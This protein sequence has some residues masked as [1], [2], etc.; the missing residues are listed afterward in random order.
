MKDLRKLVIMIA[1]MVAVLLLLAPG[2]AKADTL[3]SVKINKKNIEVDVKTPFTIKVKT[4]DLDENARIS[5]DLQKLN[6]N[7]DYGLENMG[8]IVHARSG[9]V[10]FSNYSGYV[11]NGIV[12]ICRP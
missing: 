5:Y 9:G 8:A 2:T 1:A 7:G 6:S 11:P 3:P 12:L 10:M 4:K